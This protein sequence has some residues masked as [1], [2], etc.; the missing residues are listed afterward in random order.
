MIKFVT[1]SGADIFDTSENVISVPLTISTQEKDFRDDDELNVHELLDEL[2]AYKGRSFTAC[3]STDS[4]LNAYEGGDEIYVVTLT[5]GLS[6]TY[7]SACMAARLYKETNPNARICVVDS[8]SV[9][10]EERLL[11]EK[12]LQWKQEGRTFEQID[13]DII[14]YRKKTRLFFAFQSLHNLAQ[15]GR[16]SKL[17]ASA[18]GIMNIRIVGTASAEGTVEP[19]NKCR[20]DKKALNAIF[21]E[22]KKAGYTGGRVN[23]GHIE[24]ES[25][26]QALADLIRCCYP[27]ADIT[28]YPNRGLCSY[29]GERGGL[30]LGCE[31][32]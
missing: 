19:T 12:I 1:D 7:N 17:A 6:G 15:N 13:T 5:S 16:V 32:I 20:G 29:Y 14:A 21:E 31:V 3:P 8:F 24:N 2:A 11:F 25:L 4:W 10:G 22:M 9:G 30:I 26:A 23:I 18:I 27:Q 28:I